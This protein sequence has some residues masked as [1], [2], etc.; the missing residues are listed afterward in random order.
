MKKAAVA[1]A[2]AVAAVVLSAPVHA[3]AKTVSPQPTATVSPT[4]V[5]SPSPSTSST[6]PPVQERKT[7]VRYGR[8]VKQ[9]MDVYW[10]D[11]DQLVRPVVFMI[12]GGWWSGGDKAYMKAITRSYYELGYVVV[13]VN[14]R[15][16]GDARWP[17]QR[18]DALEAIETTRR[19]AGEFGLDPNRY[20][21]IGFSA[22]GHIAA[23]IGTYGHGQPGLR[24]VV[25]V[26]PV[27]SP[28]TAYSDGGADATHEQRKLRQAAVAL[29]GGC[30]P[31]QC[32]RIWSSME[33]PFHASYG[34]APMLS[35][36]SS[37]E[38]VPPYQS[39]LLRESL[40]NYGVNMTVRKYPGTFHSSPLFR[41][42]GVAETIQTWVIG[43]LA[44]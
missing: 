36:H 10:R 7:T 6:P 4:P 33:V 11:N 39:E 16:S 8:H 37:R 12:H 35:V 15:L 29:A 9:R 34:D 31:N 42:P 23:S 1:G 17:A 5:P 25:G 2:L 32:P 14:Y 13:N 43:H 41:E 26:S 3:H 40:A 28:L 44:Y 22:G 21:V 24:A 27:I 19:M 30:G 20:A 18:D 38:F